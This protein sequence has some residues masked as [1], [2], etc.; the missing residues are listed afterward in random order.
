MACLSL[1]H[2]VIPRCTCVLM[3]LLGV[4]SHNILI[5]IRKTILLKV[6][7]AKPG[8]GI[9]CEGSVLL[10]HPGGPVV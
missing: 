10:Q 1:L 6:F 5:E 9:Q 4:V 3:Y 8:F 2:E 7:T